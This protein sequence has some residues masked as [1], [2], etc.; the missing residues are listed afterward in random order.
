MESF[1]TQNAALCYLSA[2]FQP[3]FQLPFAALFVAFLPL[4]SL[5]FATL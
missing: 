4:F 1:A 2:A 3:P 5:P